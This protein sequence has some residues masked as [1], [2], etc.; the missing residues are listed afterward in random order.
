MAYCSKCGKEL[1]EGSYFC[2]NCGE[3]VSDMQSGTQPA[4]EASGITNDDFRA[5]IGKN[6][7][8]YV[9]KFVKFRR[10]GMDHFEA[11]WH[12]PAFFVPFW[13][14]LYRKM[15][16]WAAFFLFLGFIPYIGWLINSIAGGIIANYIYYKHAKKKIVEIKL[17]SPVPET[18]RTAMIITGGVGSAALLIGAIVCTIAVIGILAAIAIPQFSAYRERGYCAAANADIKNAFVAA[19]AI[20]D[21]KPYADIS[22]V[23]ELEAYGFRPTGGVTIQIIRG[24][25]N[26][27][28]I[29]SKHEGCKKTYYIDRSGVIDIR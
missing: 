10:E 16:G 18:Q 2:Q 9:S 29:S 28:I 20:H 17:L 27:L 4:I 26:N 25:S 13:W 3:K 8:K 11:T 6:A 22:S 19:C 5:F 23:S 15:Y 21:E 24:Q 1:S 7:E 12:W 14:M